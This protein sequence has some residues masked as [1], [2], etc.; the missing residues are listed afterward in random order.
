MSSG[1]SNLVRRRSSTSLTLVSNVILDDIDVSNCPAGTANTEI[2]TL[3]AE[4]HTMG[5][6]IRDALLAM[7]EVTFAAYKVRKRRIGMVASVA[8]RVR[9]V[10]TLS[11]IVS[12]FA[13]R[14]TPS[15]R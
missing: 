5:N 8:N 9:S 6:L 2:F 10:P 7:P 3:R 13:F 12:S 11:I 4:D 14:S 1:L 15:P